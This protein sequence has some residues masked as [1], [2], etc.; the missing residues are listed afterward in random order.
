MISTFDPEPLKIKHKWGLQS[1][2]PFS[3]PGI[4]VWPYFYYFYKM[5][6]RKIQSFFNPE[7]FQGWGK[8]R[9]YFEGW[10]FKVVNADETKAFAFIPG[11]AMD[12]TGR[13]QPFIQVLDGKERTSV[14][15]LFEAEE[16]IP[17]AG[18]FNLN[19]GA[20]FFS[21][22]ILKIRLP[23]I[24]GELQFSENVPW[25]KHWYSPGIMGPYSFVPF[26]ECYHGIVSMDHS[27]HG[28]IE[29]NGEILNFDKGRGYIEKD[30][31]HSFPSAYTWMQTNHFF[32][33]G[34][35]L[36]ASVAKIPWI[37][38]SFVGFIAGLWV[39]DRLFRFTTYNGTRLLKSLI[40]EKTVEL[41]FENSNFRLE[42][43]AHRDKATALTSPVLGLMEG[44]I[45]ESM[46]SLVEVNLFDRKQRHTIFSD[47]G[48]NAG[49]E[50]A[51]KIQEIMVIK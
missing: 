38:K 37:T 40:D 49:L 36:K 25:P 43:L 2:L 11:I 7:Q 21:D 51:G 27:I 6:R 14:Q 8:T 32:K 26:M 50:V 28:E 39:H 16:F 10:Y 44:R 29:Y 19:I 18:R 48:R 33:P 45:E 41:V 12:E 31:G 42:L 30:W 34:I 13:Q 35:S 5:I 3:E 22:Q 23:G 4:S 9:K 17:V 24:T 1:A 15:H 46:T 47:T 20:S